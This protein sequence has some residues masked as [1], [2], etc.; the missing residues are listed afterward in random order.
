ME[1]LLTSSSTIAIQWNPPD[2]D[3]SNGVIR[4]YSIEIFN[5]ESGDSLTLT[6]PGTS[7][8]VS[9]LHPYYNY[10]V[11]VAAVTVSQGVQSTVDFQMAEDGRQK[12]ITFTHITDFL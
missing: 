6:T 2:A 11:S 7:Y 9:N 3:K 4:Y 10:N 1:V 5:R 12:L 8:D